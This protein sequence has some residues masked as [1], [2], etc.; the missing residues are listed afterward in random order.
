[1][2]PVPRALPL[3]HREFGAGPPLVLVH[4]LFG[5]GRNW[6][7]I[8]RALGGRWRV[9]LPDL[10]NHGDSPHDPCMT[11]PDLVADLLAFAERERLGPCPWLGHSLGGRAVMRLALGAPQ[12]VT[13]LVVVDAAPVPTPDRFTLLLDALEALPL[14]PEIGRAQLDAL[15]AAPVADA[16][17]RAFLLS[18]L[19][20]EPSGWQWRVNLGALRQ[21]L[22]GL[23]DFPL[24]A[25]ARCECPALFLAGGRSPYDLPA[26]WP[27]IQRHWPAA[28]MEVFPDAGHWLHAEEPERLVAVLEDFLAS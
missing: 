1:M 22:P 26:H 23:L 25:H 16:T 6:Q 3:A 4:G 19:V 9:L 7:R 27:L 20:R 18:N 5:S 28:R 8:A 11:W 24:P 21:A 17:L 12:A 2:S 15:L 10:R 14:T 13:R